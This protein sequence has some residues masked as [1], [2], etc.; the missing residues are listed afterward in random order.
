MT[1][2]PVTVG[3]IADLLHD[4][5]ALSFPSPADPAARAELLARK[6]DLLARIA[7]QHADQWTC[8]HA[9]QARQVARDA[10]IL[11]IQARQIGEPAQHASSRVGPNQRR[12][13]RPLALSGGAESEENSG[14]SS[15]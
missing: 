10:Q 1:D 2:Q 6:A 9:D 12:T 11:A 13:N 3:E 5:R 4:I 14:A 7:E 8:Q 15:A